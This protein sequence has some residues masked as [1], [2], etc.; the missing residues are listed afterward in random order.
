MGTKREVPEVVVQRLPRYYQLLESLRERQVQDVSSSDLAELLG[1]TPSQFRSD[2]AHFGRFGR[3]GHGYSVDEL[4]EGLRAVLG[5]SVRHRAVIVG[6]GYLAHAFLHNFRYA[7]SSFTLCAA[8]DTCRNR[9]GTDVMGVPVYAPDEMEAYVR[10]N[11]IDAALLMLPRE[12]AQ[13]IVDRLAPLGVRGFWN[14]SNLELETDR[15]DVYIE[16]VHFA[17]SLLV[18]GYHLAQTGKADRRGE[19]S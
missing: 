9:I 3:K 12:E 17:D 19:K 18:L 15:D 11:R 5:V 4:C 8:F 1:V 6:M 16:N 14:F 13:G 7:K 10:E 2:L